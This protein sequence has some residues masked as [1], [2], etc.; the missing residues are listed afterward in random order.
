MKMIFYGEL[1]VFI[2]TIVSGMPAISKGYID[3][4]FINEFAYSYRKIF[5]I[6]IK[7][8]SAFIITTYDTPMLYAKIAQQ[9]YGIILKNKFLKI[10]RNITSE[11]LHNVILRNKNI[12]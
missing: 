4:I 11:N 7:N 9:D 6:V 5:P 12:V 10:L 3:R 2:I 1:S 8:K